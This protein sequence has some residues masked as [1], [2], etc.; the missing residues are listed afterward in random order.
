MTSSHFVLSPCGNRRWLQHSLP[1]L[2]TNV[3]C[4]VT[5]TSIH[6]DARNARGDAFEIMRD[7]HEIQASPGGKFEAAII[8]S[9]RASNSDMA[10]GLVMYSSAPRLKACT[11]FSV[12]AMAVSMNTGM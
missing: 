7:A 9:T 10:N 12:E 5:T 4:F 6:R 8:D 2:V 3:A 11:L 1:V